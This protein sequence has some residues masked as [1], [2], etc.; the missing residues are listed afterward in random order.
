M[1][2]VQGTEGLLVERNHVY[3]IPPNT[4]LLISGLELRIAPRPTDPSQYTPIHAFLGSLAMA[5][6]RLIGFV[7]SGTASDGSIGINKIKE[8]GGITIAQS[9]DSAKYDGMP[10]AAIATGAIDLVLTPEEIGAKLAHLAT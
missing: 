6:R 10:R 3:V 1:P 4:Q 7:V 5:W 2:V 9:P 8:A